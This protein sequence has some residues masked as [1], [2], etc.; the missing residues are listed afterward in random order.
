M[1]RTPLLIIGA[2]PTCL[3]AAWRL[4]ARGESDWMLC[5]AA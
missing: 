3:G 4:L 5:E 1:T 2:G